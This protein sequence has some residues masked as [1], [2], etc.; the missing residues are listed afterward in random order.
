MRRERSFLEPSGWFDRLVYAAL[1]GLLPKLIL[2]ESASDFSVGILL[3]WW[4][5]VTYHTVIF[6]YRITHA[7]MRLWLRRF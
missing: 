5:V 1:V 2:Q 6:I 7:L 3:F 4:V